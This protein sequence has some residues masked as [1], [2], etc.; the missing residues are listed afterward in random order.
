MAFTK[1]KSI[2]EAIDEIVAASRESA[3]AAPDVLSLL[4][5]NLEAN[6]EQHYGAWSADRQNSSLIR[7][8]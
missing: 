2:K 6:V 8:H 4:T 5:E 7:V 3:W 1:L